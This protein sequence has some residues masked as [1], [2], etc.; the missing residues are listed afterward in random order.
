M[1]V[2]NKNI[3]ILDYGVGNLKSIK[4]CIKKIGYNPVITSDKMKLKKCRAIILPG[5]GSFSE[6]I[7]VVKKKN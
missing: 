6:A 1:I 5:V 7:K 2:N 3:A 4:N